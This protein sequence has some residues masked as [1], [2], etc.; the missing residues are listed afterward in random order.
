VGISACDVMK[1]VMGWDRAWMGPRGR[2]Y[3]EG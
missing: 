2:E 1:S 3:V